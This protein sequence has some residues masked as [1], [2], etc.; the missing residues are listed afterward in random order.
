LPDSWVVLLMGYNVDSEGKVFDSAETGPLVAKHS[1]VPVYTMDQTRFT[2]G[3]V[4][5][6]LLSGE[7]QGEIASSLASKILEGASAEAIPIVRGPVAVSLFDHAAMQR[8]GLSPADLPEGSLVVNTPTSFYQ[9]YRYRIWALAAFVSALM[10]LS[11]ALIINILSRRRDV[12]EKKR[13]EEALRRSEERF[14]AAFQTSPD[15]ICITGVS[16]GTYLTINK[17]F[18]RMAGWEEQDVLGRSS[19]DL[20]IW[21]DPGDRARLVEGLRAEGVVRNLEADFCRKDGRVFSGLMSASL[22]SIAGVPSLLSVTRDVTEWKRS[23]GERE[24]LEEQLRQ[25]QKMEAIGQLAGGVAHDFNN[26]L[27][28]ILSNTEALQEDLDRDVGAS[29]AKRAL[30]QDIGVAGQ[31][32]RDLTRQLL[33]FARRQV[34]APVPLDLNALVRGGQNLLRR[35]LG[36][37]IELVAALQPDLWPVRCD[38]GQMEQVILNLAVNARDAMPGGGQLA[39]ETANVQIDGS[40]A[41]SQQGMRPGPHVRVAIRDSGQG[42][43]PE[44]KARIFEPFFT[45]KPKGRG[46]G[47]G[48]ATVY[49]IVKQSE[50]YILVESEPG[51]GTTFELYLPRVVAEVTEVEAA[52]PDREMRPRGS[53]TV[54]VVEDDPLV[55]EVT[56]RSLRTGGYRVLV[57]ADGR[58]ALDVAAGEQDMRLLVTDVV[59][60]GMSGREVADEL[61]PRHPGLRVLYVSGYTQDAIAQRGVLES[62]VEFLPKPF[63][64]S[65]LLERV[66]AV[67]DTRSQAK[68]TSA[69]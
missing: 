50:G 28:V 9:R 14:R 46:T 15:A 17:S 24:R 60:P 37:D 26:L 49:G 29:P 36:E 42:M 45:T 41:A 39:I 58:D 32:A 13:A 48:L 63:T 34:I 57:A 30:V 55:R 20:G 22:I 11:T 7:Q 3:V 51:S 61:C 4:G 25:A 18:T 69:P 43:S 47:L 38:P 1:R 6:S 35:V 68:E 64:A 12:T 23:Q 66:R 5:G 27:T 31:L 40:R 16:D 21:V 8:F 52:P 59:M 33:A 53:E 54:L 56:V 65:S 2:G 19:L 62:G 67:L 44:V 10:A